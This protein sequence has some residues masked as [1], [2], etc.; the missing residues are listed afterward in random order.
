MDNAL[1]LKISLYLNY[2]VFAILLNSV[3]IVILKSMSN[4]HVDEVQASTLELFKDLSIAGVSFLVA[5]ILPKLGYKNA[6]LLGLAIVIAGCIIMQITNSFN[7]ARILFAMV[8]TSFALIKVSVYS[9]IGYVTNSQK[10]HSAL[11]SSIEGVFMFGIAIAY[12]LFPAFNDVQ[13]PDGWLNVYWLLAALSFA[14]FC[15]LYFTK[16]ENTIAVDNGTKPDLTAMFKLMSLASVFVF[17]ISAFLFVMIEQGVMTWLPT[18]NKT[19][20]QLPENISIMM[21]SILAI[22]LGIGRIFAGYLSSKFSWLKL[23]IVFIFCAMLN[24]I[25]ILPKTVGM[26][27]QVINHFSDIPWVAFAF[28]LVGFFIAPIYPI[29]N[30]IILSSLPK[31]KH[32]VMTGLII[33]FSALGG[34]LGSR[35]IG[36]LFA[37]VGAENAFYYLLIPMVLIV[38]SMISLNRLVGKKQSMA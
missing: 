16:L 32:S 6:M 23:L 12:F 25:F 8:G 37:N 31:E 35:I 38:I 27:P 5:S 21:S 20:L 34:T 24:V 13:N 4:Y 36:Y 30:S 22:S 19:V 2:F 1:R 18:F 33:V 14:A 15:F 29:L 7:G 26:S 28:P 9:M 17:L 10:E 3:G 11:M